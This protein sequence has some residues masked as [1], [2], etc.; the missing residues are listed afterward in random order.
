MGDMRNKRLFWELLLLGVLVGLYWVLQTAS[1]HIKQ[2]T[3][4]S[5]YDKITRLVENKKCFKNVAESTP[6]PLNKETLLLI[7]L[8][9]DYPVK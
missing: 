8:A 6:K 2:V 3:I 9:C 7:K 5:D 4:D 1:P